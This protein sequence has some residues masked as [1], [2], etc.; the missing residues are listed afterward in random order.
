MNIFFIF[1]KKLFKE[2]E[3]N[4]P[5]IKATKPTFLKALTLINA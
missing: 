2:N 1:M 4:T 5:A 3:K